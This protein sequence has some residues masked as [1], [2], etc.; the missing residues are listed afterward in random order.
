M[1]RTARA[2]S[3]VPPRAAFGSPSGSAPARA[4]PSAMPPADPPPDPPDRIGPLL[5]RFLERLRA[6]PDLDTEAFCAEQPADLREELRERCRALEILYRPHDAGGGPSESEGAEAGRRFGDFRVLRELGRGGMGIVYLVWQESLR[7]QVALK[8]LTRSRSASRMQLARFHQEALAAARL[9]HPGIVPVYAV[10]ETDGS[11]WFA[12]EYV[13]GTTLAQEVDHLRSR[14]P[15][16]PGDAPRNPAARKVDIERTA[17]VAAEVAEALH[18]AHQ[19]GLIHRDVK[20]HNILVDTEGRARLLDFGL[21]KDMSA[22]TLSRSGDIAGTLF[23]I[24]PEQALAK[25]VLVDHRTDVYSLGVVLYEM[26]SLQRP[27]D[28]RSSH[29]VLYR[30]SFYDPPLVRR[31]NPRVPRDLETI[32]AKAM[33]KDPA[34]RYASA[35]AMAADLRRFLAHEAILA[36]PPAWWERAWRTARRNRGT[37][38]AAA[39]GVLALAAGVL[40]SQ[41][42]ARRPAATLPK[43]AIECAVEGAR[44][45]AHPLD[46]ATGQ[47][48]PEAYPL[49][50]TPLDAT[51]IPPGTWRIVVE[52]PG[53]GFAELTERFSDPSETRRLVAVIR[54]TE[55]VVADGMAFVAAGEFEFGDP[56]TT[57]GPLRARR[58]TLDAFWIDDHEVTHA[59]YR[60]F[61]AAEPA[62]AP[63]HW[64]G[65]SESRW[66]DLP[67]VLV[68]RDDAEAYARWRGKRLPTALEWERAARGRDGRHVPWGD[69]PAPSGACATWIEGRLPSSA[70]GDAALALFE[71]WAR[72]SRSCP[73]LASPEGILHAFGNVREWTETP[74]FQHAASGWEVL[75]GVHVVKGNGWHESPETWS[76][77]RTATTPGHA[78]AVDLGFRCAKSASP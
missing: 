2:R 53:A 38:V 4:L 77:E 32:C 8:V 6:D 58:E 34:H 45:T 19:E 56:L 74:H 61:V 36:Q 14:S 42:W 11:H 23:Y 52:Q 43:V 21:A 65:A 35:E 57:D 5:D 22:D 24:S 27:F 25:R 54:P 20:P 3:S 68:S 39:V 9:K 55:E 63:R 10:G 69:G 73:E 44:V 75:P 78:V 33:E 15:T 16:P 12:M 31:V 17:R 41:M 1:G 48:S 37:V 62:R 7:R 76:L 67:V 71:R 18:A 26:L 70:A 59:E 64:S 47:I 72:P 28:G 50:T 40:G 46:P 51:P 13:P 66:S 29:E 49:G 30:I 60:D